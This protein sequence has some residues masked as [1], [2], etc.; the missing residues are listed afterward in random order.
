MEYQPHVSEDS[1][2]TQSFNAL[3]KITKTP[4]HVFVS[5]KI[6]DR[7]NGQREDVEEE[8]Y[9]VFAS[10]CKKDSAFR[11]VDEKLQS[12]LCS[13]HGCVLFQGVY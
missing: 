10:F 4:Y 12:Y 11:F 13:F 6:N 1:D 9:K 3:I 7:A 2:F 8:I 5:Q